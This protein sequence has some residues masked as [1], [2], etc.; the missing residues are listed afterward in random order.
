MPQDKISYAFSACRLYG[1][2]N[3]K[4]SQLTKLIQQMLALN[5]RTHNFVNDVRLSALNKVR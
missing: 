5:D 3:A 4:P 1:A 2:N